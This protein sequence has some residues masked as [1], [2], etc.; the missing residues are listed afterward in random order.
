MLDK[1]SIEIDKEDE[2]ADIKRKKA[3][4]KIKDNEIRKWG[5]KYIT[6]YI[7]KGEKS[8]LQKLQIKD[9]KGNTVH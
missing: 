6:K 3:M 5:F 8:A 9:E 1:Y 2:R 4:K 7:S